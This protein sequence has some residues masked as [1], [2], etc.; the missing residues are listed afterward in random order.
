M[1]SEKE[2]AC[3]Q[4]YGQKAVGLSFNPSGSNAKKKN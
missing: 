2:T 1:S 4:T 3:S